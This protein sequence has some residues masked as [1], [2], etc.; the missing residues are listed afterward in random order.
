M[1]LLIALCLIWRLGTLTLNILTI[2]LKKLHIFGGKH[3]G[4]F[5]IK[6]AIV[7]LENVEV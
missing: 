6:T 1:H 4:W 5:H 2:N 3:K 7:D